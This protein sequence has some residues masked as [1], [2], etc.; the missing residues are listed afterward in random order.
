V[1]GASTWIMRPSNY[2]ASPCWYSAPKVLQAANGSIAAVGPVTVR[3]SSSTFPFRLELLSP[4]VSRPSRPTINM[5]AIVNVS[6]VMQ[7][8]GC[9]HGMQI[10]GGFLCI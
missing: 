10:F 6:R 4:Q 2:V 1:W 9:M 8:R 7:Q 3:R 5:K